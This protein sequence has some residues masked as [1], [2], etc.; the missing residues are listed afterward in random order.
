MEGQLQNVTGEWKDSSSGGSLS[1]T[2][3]DC[4]TGSVT[5]IVRKSRGGEKEEKGGLTSALTDN[6][7]RA[8]GQH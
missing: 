8:V 6:A 2:I 1:V 7:S 4:K 5:K 3:P